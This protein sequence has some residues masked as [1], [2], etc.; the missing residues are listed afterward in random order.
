M[1]ASYKIN[2]LILNVCLCGIDCFMEGCFYLHFKANNRINNK[3]C[4][5][6][7]FSNQQL[8]SKVEFI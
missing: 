7:H 6:D 1:S 4:S 8:S 5:T 3:R 2:Y